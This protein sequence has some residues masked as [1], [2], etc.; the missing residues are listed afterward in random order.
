[1]KTPYLHNPASGYPKSVHG[2]AAFKSPADSADA[3]ATS[4]YVEESSCFPFS[5]ASSNDCTGIK[6]HDLPVETVEKIPYQELY[7]YLP[8]NKYEPDDSDMP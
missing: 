5:C 1:M 6:T 2:P 8:T 7:P 3:A 4:Y